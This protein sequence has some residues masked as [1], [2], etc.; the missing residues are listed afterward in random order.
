[1][2]YDVIR[3]TIF[4]YIIVYTSSLISSKC[5]NLNYNQNNHLYPT[6]DPTR[7]P[8]FT[9]CCQRSENC[10]RLLSSLETS[11]SSLPPLSAFSS[12]SSLIHQAI[13]ESDKRHNSGLD[14]A[15]TGWS[16]W[17]EPQK[18]KELQGGVNAGHPPLCDK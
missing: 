17:V 9:S 10:G 14:G 1:M 3:F 5:K 13:E 18:A 15:S 16:D 11:S 8:I 12:L 7:H 6:S 4:L 2:R